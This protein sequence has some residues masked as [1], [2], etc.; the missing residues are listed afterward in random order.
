VN[1]LVENGSYHMQNMGDVGMLQV[2][3]NRILNIFPAD[4]RIFVLTT[5]PEKLKK[6]CPSAIPVSGEGRKAWQRKTYFSKAFNRFPGKIADAYNNFEKSQ[7]IHSP[8]GAYLFKRYFSNVKRREIPGLIEYFE[9]IKHADAVVSTGGGLIND[10]FVDSS[11]AVLD[12]FITAQSFGKPTAMFGLGFGPVENP[13]TIEKVRNVFPK[14]KMLCFREGLS[15]LPLLDSLGIPRELV[16]ITGD[17][18]IELAYRERKQNPGKGIGFN[19]RIY[20]H[21][22]VPPEAI[23][24]IGQILSNITKELCAEIIPTPVTFRTSHSDLASIRQVLGSLAVDTTQAEKIIMPIDL[25]HQISRCRI[26]I[27]GAYHSA[28]YALA[29]GIPVIALAK[30]RYYQNKFAGLSDQFGTGCKIVYYDDP[31][32][33]NVL[34]NEIVALW[35]NADQYQSPLLSAAVSQIAESESAWGRFAMGLS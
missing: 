23:V 33:S 4:T 25:I 12:T 26:V 10:W 18:A 8:R 7:T 34:S 5:N 11:Q 22:Q 19:I 27:T 2:G 13:T 16:S 28:V 20:R 6:I 15:S 9:A 17:D 1:I 14:L 29:Q 31:D 24:Q 30:S 32:F 3:L 21:S 35:K